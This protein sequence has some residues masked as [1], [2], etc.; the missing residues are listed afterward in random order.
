MSMIIRQN[1]IKFTLLSIVTIFGLSVSHLSIGMSDHLM[2][3]D[4]H[5]NAAA[6]QNICISIDTPLAQQRLSSVEHIEKEPRLLYL[7]LIVTSI[8]FIGLLLASRKLYVSS[9]W[10][11]PDIVLLTG[12]Y[13]S[14]L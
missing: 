10:K 8:V 9:S 11:P 13:T 4:N 2:G 3:M 1:I 6:C 7:S 14:S 12:K 5:V